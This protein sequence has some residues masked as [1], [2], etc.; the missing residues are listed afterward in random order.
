MMRNFFLRFIAN[1]VG[2]YVVDYFLVNFCFLS[3]AAETCPD[4]PE[5]NLLAF[6]VGGFALGLLNTFVKPLLK[7]LSMP[8]TFLSAGLFIFVINGFLLAL[9]VW[10]VNTLALESAQILVL[11]DPIWATYLYAAVILG[12][13]NITTHW[14]VK[15]S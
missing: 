10:L 5:A 11:G 8:I 1:S 12:L 4:Q 14:L 7:L 13:F 2:L 6:A 3:A 9:L 15:K